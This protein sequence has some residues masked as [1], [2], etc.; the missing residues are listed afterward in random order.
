MA[1]L[2]WSPA[3]PTLLEARDM[4]AVDDIKHPPELVIAISQLPQGTIIHHLP[5]TDQFP[6]VAS[7]EVDGL[8]TALQSIPT[9]TAEHLLSA[10]HRT[11]LIKDPYEIAMIRK[12]NDISSRAHEVVMRVLGLAVAGNIKKQYPHTPHL[13]GEWLIEKEAEAEAIFVASCRR[14][15]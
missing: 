8:K 9:K 12:A 7:G 10:L 2:V 1:D 5:E 4:Y 13:P 11:R 3:P 6:N 15:G 14:E